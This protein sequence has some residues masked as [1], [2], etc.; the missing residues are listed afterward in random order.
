MTELRYHVVTSYLQ[1]WRTYH[2]QV[3]RLSDGKTAYFDSWHLRLLHWKV[4]RHRLDRHYRSL[5][6]R[7]A[8]GK[9]RERFSR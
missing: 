6:A 4:R 3:T 2:A 5:D 8:A 7:D 9:F 1:S